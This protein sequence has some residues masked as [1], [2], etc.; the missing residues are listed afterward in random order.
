MENP[1]YY[2][3][4]FGWNN[5]LF[6]INFLISGEESQNHHENLKN[7]K[8][9]C[10]EDEMVLNPALSKSY[11]EKFKMFIVVNKFFLL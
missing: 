5:P 3:L 2:F 9:L 8:N 11:F 4:R 7:S 1:N 10:K 6:I